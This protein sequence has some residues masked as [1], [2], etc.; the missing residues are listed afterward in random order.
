M[1][2]TRYRNCERKGPFRKRT[3]APRSAIKLPGGKQAVC[4]YLSGVVSG[5]TSALSKRDGFLSQLLPRGGTDFMGPLLVS[6]GR[7]EFRR[8]MSETQ[9]NSESVG[10][11]KEL[12]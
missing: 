2:P 9:G 6:F 8:K 1:R 10:P 5:R 7:S 11:F 3:C 12:V 4:E